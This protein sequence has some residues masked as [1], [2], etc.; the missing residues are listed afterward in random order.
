LHDTRARNVLRSDIQLHCISFTHA[1]TN[2]SWATN[3]QHRAGCKNA[4][5]AWQF[6]RRVKM[7]T[8]SE[9]RDVRCAAECT[10]RHT[11]AP[12]SLASG[13]TTCMMR[14]PALQNKSVQRYHIADT[15]ARLGRRAHDRAPDSRMSM[16]V[17]N[18]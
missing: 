13:K 8:I 15:R 3:A 14:S 1:S 18:A 12:E 7:T 16:A 11:F 4:A 6:M 9:A 10:L 5:K 17:F 2:S